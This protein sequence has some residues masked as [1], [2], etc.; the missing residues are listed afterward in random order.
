MIKI[1]NIIK[2]NKQITITIFNFDIKILNQLIKNFFF[3]LINN[4]VSLKHFRN[5]QHD[6]NLHKMHLFH[7]RRQFIIITS[8]K[9]IF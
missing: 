6:K 8:S 9:K 4:N 1:N 7:F 2:I 3:Q 5:K